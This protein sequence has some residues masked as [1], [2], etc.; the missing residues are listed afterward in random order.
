MSAG[1]H[2]ARI[3]RIHNMYN[4]L[5]QLFWYFLIYSFAGWC[6]GV[7]Y[8]AAKKHRFVNT[9]F[10]NLPFCPIYGFGGILF[11]IFLSELKSNLFF[12]FIGGIILS[13]ALMYITGLLLE[14]FF[15]RKWWD[16]S[17]N[18]FQFEGYISFPLAVIFG[19]LGVLCIRVTNPLLLT[20]LSLIPRW[21]GRIILL[22]ALIL[23]TLDFLSALTA[24]LQLK[25]RI[26]RL[27]EMTQDMQ[28]ISDSFGNAITGRIQRRMM[29]AYPNLETSKL[30]AEQ[31]ETKKTQKE[32]AEKETFAKGC[33]FYKLTALF[34]IGAFLGDVVETIFCRITSGVWMSRSSVVYGAFSIVWGLACAILTAL[35]YKYKDKSDRYLFICGTVLGGAYEYICS[36]FTELAFG[37]VFWDY[38]DIP[39]NLGG[40]I[41]L[42]Y[43]FFWGIAAVVWLKGIYPFLSGLIEK[44]PKKAG[45]PVTWFLIIFMICNMLLS[46]MALGRYTQRQS[47]PQAQTTWEQFLDSH[48]PDDRIEKIYPNLKVVD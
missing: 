17:K 14:R 41:N 19:L 45:V 37:T 3:R 27:N 5:Y 38:S 42:L 4:T 23:L 9:G 28:R 7:I 34:F 20:L 44:I 22:A 32:K 40:R 1:L 13:S 11:T 21:I 36:V 31:A 29:K 15:Q 24:A 35:L 33:G 39:F 16:F 10:L 18:R 12:L 25:I 26:R 47:E 30:L 6:A 2:P 8:S 46:A 48:F 43:C